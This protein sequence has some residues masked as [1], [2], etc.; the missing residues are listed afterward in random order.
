MGGGGAGTAVA[1]DNVRRST[2]ATKWRIFWEST[3][4]TRTN[5][6]SRRM[7]SAND[8]A[9]V[10]RSHEGELAEI[11]LDVALERREL[12]RLLR[13]LHHRGANG[14]RHE[15]Q[16]VADR[17]SASGAGAAAAPRLR[18]MLPP[19]DLFNRRDPPPL[20]REASHGSRA[21]ALVCGEAGAARGLLP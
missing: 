3:A 9:R 12:R 21:T 8:A 19:A 16:S 10:P 18:S 7:P 1:R 14:N 2:A 15:G 11:G 13:L 5:G 20:P 17:E 4:G 6:C